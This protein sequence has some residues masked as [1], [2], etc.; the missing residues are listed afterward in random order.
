MNNST[1]NAVIAIRNAVNTN[2]IA[3]TID[4]LN[5]LIDSLCGKAVMFTTI[6]FDVVR[7]QINDVESV[8]VSDSMLVL[9]RIDDQVTTLGSKSGTVSVTVTWNDGTVEKYATNN[10]KWVQL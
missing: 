3:Q 4:G 5:T 7:H 6:G 9:S 10:G 1:L 2:T 8:S